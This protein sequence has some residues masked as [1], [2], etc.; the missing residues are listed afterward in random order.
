MRTCRRGP[1]QASCPRS[2]SLLTKD[3]GNLIERS[4]A[5]PQP[6]SAIPPLCVAEVAAH[7]VG[8]RGKRNACFVH[9]LVDKRVQGGER[10]LPPA[11]VQKFVPG[12]RLVIHVELG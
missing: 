9:G 6:R 2:N 1:W 8:K 4:E 7:V 10:K 11:C 3:L 5:F 12:V